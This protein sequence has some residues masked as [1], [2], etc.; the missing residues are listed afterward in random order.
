M[1]VRCPACDRES[2]HAYRCSECGKDLVGDQ[3]VAQEEG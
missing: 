2:E 1:T 3:T